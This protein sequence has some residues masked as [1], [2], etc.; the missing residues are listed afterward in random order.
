MDLGSLDRFYTNFVARDL[1]AKVVPGAILLLTIA[2]S[3][4]DGKID[5]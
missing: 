3:I 4:N 1:F 5:P 2:W